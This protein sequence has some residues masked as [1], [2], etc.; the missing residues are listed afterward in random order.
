LALDYDLKRSSLTYLAHVEGITM[1]ELPDVEIFKHYLN[2]TSLHKKIESAK[3]TDKRILESVS[4]NGLTNA[5]KGKTFHSTR[6]HG[7]YLFV[8]LNDYTFLVLH[9]GMTGFLKYFKKMD[10]QPD[11]ARLLIEFANGYHLAYDCQRMLGQVSL[12]EKVEKFIKLNDLGV[13]AMAVDLET[14]RDVLGN[15]RAKVKSALMNQKLLA[16]IGNVYSDEILFQA[17]VHPKT[18]ANT[19][20]EER[21][22]RILSHMRKVLKTAI[23][24]RA[25][26][27]KMPKSYI[28]L[29]R[30]SEGK[31]PRCGREIVKEKISGRS[32]Y[33]CPK[34]QR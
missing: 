22:E 29:Q 8:E 7:K 17:E 20:S 19:L 32:A 16:G 23:D 11:H 31:C 10:K 24:C 3:V 25:D 6:R 30:H 15:T 12:T 9:F 14:L 2:A 34:C 33:F 13:D 5:L 4:Q 28:L 27:E 18:K 1:P 26:P 21:L